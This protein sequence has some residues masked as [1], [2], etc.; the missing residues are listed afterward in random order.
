MKRYFFRVQINHF[1]T[2]KLVGS[3]H[4]GLIGLRSF[5]S[6]IPSFRSVANPVGSK[7]R[8]GAIALLD[9]IGLTER[10]KTDA[11]ASADGLGQK[12]TSKHVGLFMSNVR[13]TCGAGLLC[14][15]I[16]A[17]FSF[18]QKEP[19]CIIDSCIFTG[20]CTKINHNK[21]SFSDVDEWVKS[22]WYAWWCFFSV[23]LILLRDAK[24]W[25]RGCFL[26]C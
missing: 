2:Q 16:S 12:C 5:D 24:D 21:R 17:V 22:L 6:M 4:W 1:L 8:S 23:W 3:L 20:D 19:V 9:S 14:D 25:L 7:D 15:T 10:T 18:G 11:P 26:I 13:G